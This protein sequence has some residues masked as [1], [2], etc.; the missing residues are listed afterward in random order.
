MSEYWKL[1][2]EVLPLS[3]N[4]KWE[5]ARGE[6]HIEIVD[7]DDTCSSECLCGHQNIRYLNYM[8]NKINGNKIMVGSCCV[9]KFFEIKS[10]YL[11]KV[12]EFLKRDEVAILSLQYI[13]DLHFQDFINECDF[14]FYSKFSTSKTK[15]VSTISFK[16]MLLHNQIKPIEFLRISYINMKIL[17]TIKPFIENSILIAIMQTYQS[18]IKYYNNK[19][20]KF[21]QDFK[22]L[23]YMIYDVIKNFT[24]LKNKSIYKCEVS[25]YETKTYILTLNCCADD[26]IEDNNYIKN[27]I[28]GDMQNRELNIDLGWSELKDET[29]DHKIFCFPLS[30]FIN[31]VIDDVKRRDL[32]DNKTF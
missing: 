9:E 20:S 27:V 7:E 12:I 3:E 4:N 8:K 28:C 6:W 17:N 29:Y 30:P 11:T 5:D 25:S 24:D 31:N 13:T 15:N 2:E 18:K 21:N 23:N 1:I 26:G 16:R 22:Y 14:Q 19:K 10:V 32:T